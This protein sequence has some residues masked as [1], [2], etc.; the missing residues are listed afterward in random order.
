MHVSFRFDDSP[1]IREAVS[2]RPN[3]FCRAIVPGQEPDEV[4]VAAGAAVAAGD[5]RAN[6][7]GIAMNRHVVVLALL[8]RGAVW[9]IDAGGEGAAGHH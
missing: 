2:N 5:H 1:R 3:G 9:R 8:V 6:K 7:L 4:L